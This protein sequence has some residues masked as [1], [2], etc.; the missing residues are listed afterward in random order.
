MAAIEG[1]AQLVDVAGGFIA[2][3]EFTATYGALDD[4]Q[5]VTQLYRNVLGREP[6][7]EGLAYHVARLQSGASRAQV[8]VGFSESPENIAA[9]PTANGV[10]YIRRTQ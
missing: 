2:A 10:R 3:P 8:L 4:A 1:G 6:E 7:P 5:F 9:T